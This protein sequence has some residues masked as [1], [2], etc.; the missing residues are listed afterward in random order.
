MTK[1]VDT[2]HPIIIG[3]VDTYNKCIK[4]SD[5]IDIETKAKRSFD[6]PIFLISNRN[7]PA[8][9]ENFWIEEKQTI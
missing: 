3:V 8:Y 9:S 1:V 4:D 2:N 5:G 7:E 6:P